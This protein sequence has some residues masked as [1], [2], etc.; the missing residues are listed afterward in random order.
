MRGSILFLEDTSEDVKRLE[1]ILYGLF[2]SGRFDRVQG[3]FFG[4]L[5]LTGG[6]FEDFMGRFN[7]YLST[8]LRLDLPLY[9]SPDFGH[10]LK[11]KP[12]PMGTLAAIEATDFGSR[13]TVE[14]FSLKKG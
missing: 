14:T 13:L 1:N 10:G 12:L 3:I 9:Y 2:D 8:A 7:S 11:N 4:N 5:P 6:S